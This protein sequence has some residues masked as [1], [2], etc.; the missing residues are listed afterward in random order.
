MCAVGTSN[1]REEGTLY[2]CG[3]AGAACGYAIRVGYGTGAG[4][5]GVTRTTYDDTYET[6]RD[7]QGSVRQGEEQLKAPS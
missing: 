7:A 2:G 5:T 4:G 3:T 1:G 6:S